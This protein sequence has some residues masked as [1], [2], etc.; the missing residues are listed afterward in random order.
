MSNNN[1]F[2]CLD[3]GSFC[4]L[5]INNKKKRRAGQHTVTGLV[6]LE[7]GC[8]AVKANSHRGFWWFTSWPAAFSYCNKKYRASLALPPQPVCGFS[9]P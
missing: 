7:N 4:S 1:S 9:H 5:K 2:V 8:G 3:P 6:H